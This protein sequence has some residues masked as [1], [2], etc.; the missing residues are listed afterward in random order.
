[1]DIAAENS[2]I[3]GHSTADEVRILILHGLLHLAGNDHEK[4]EGEMARKEQ[5][6]RQKLGL[7]S[8]LIARTEGNLDTSSKKSAKARS[9]R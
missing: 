4:D 5:R 2:K 6:L 1:M 3:F 7:P 8:N 9:A